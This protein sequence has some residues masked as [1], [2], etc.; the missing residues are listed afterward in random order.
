[1]GGISERVGILDLN[2]RYNWPGMTS[3]RIKSILFIMDVVSLPMVMILKCKEVSSCTGV[4]WASRKE[5]PSNLLCLSNVP[6][7]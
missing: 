2:K 1:M 3:T 5:Y 6:S 7:Y 4:S